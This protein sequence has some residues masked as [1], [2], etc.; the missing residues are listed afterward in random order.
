VFIDERSRPAGVLME[1]MING[2]A[3]TDAR[4]FQELTMVGSG[5]LTLIGSAELTIAGS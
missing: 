1:D 3:G 5:E 2:N 4:R